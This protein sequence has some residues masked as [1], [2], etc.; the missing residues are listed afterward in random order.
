M[1]N[2]CSGYEEDKDLNM[3]ITNRGYVQGISKFSNIN[4]NLVA[5]STVPNIHMTTHML[6]ISCAINI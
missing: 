6:F 1:Y 5:R 3:I 4:H 2:Y